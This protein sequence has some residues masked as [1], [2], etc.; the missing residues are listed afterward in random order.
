MGMDRRVQFIVNSHPAVLNGFI[1]MAREAAQNH[2][3]S[4][5]RDQLAHKPALPKQSL[6]KREAQL[7]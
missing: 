5:V 3:R 7:R 4:S 6:A 2:Q 1:R